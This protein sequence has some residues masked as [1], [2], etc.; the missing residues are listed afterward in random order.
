LEY[1]RQRSLK[2]DLKIIVKTLPSVLFKR[3]GW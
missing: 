1:L 2:R 3:R